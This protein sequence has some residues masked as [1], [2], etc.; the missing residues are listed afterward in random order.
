MATPK[1]VGL[2]LEFDPKIHDWTVHINRLEQFFVANTITDSDIK[3]AI[4]LNGLSQEAYILLQNLCV[5]RKP[6]ENVYEEVV[7]L[8]NEYYCRKTNVFAERC[9]FYAARKSP[10]ENIQD[11]AVKLRS[12]C[13]KCEFGDQL[14]HILR[15]K[16]ICGLNPGKIMDKMLSECRATTTFE[17]AVSLATA[18]EI[19]WRNQDENADP[20]FIKEEPREIYRV[21]GTPPRREVQRSAA[22]ARSSAVVPARNREV[23]WCSICGRGKHPGSKCFFKNKEQQPRYC[24]H[25]ST[26][27]HNTSNCRN[28][29]EKV[30]NVQLDH[31]NE[32]CDIEEFPIFTVESNVSN[33]MT[34]EVLLNNKLFILELD[35]GAAVSCLPYSVY[36]KYFENYTLNPTSITLINFTGGRISPLGKINIEVKYNNEIKFIE[37]CVIKESTVAIL[38]RDFISAFN[39][40]FQAVNHIANN[41]TWIE[42]LKLKFPDVFTDKIG[43]FNKFKLKLFLEENS[44]PKVFK[45]RPLPYALK[46][47]VERELN[48]L[49]DINILTPIEHSDW[50]T[51][52]VPVLKEDGSVRICGD[53]KLTLNP[54]L[55]DD[56]Y[57]IPRIDDL[58]A[59]LNG[60]QQFS[61]IDLS[62]AYQQIELENESAELTAI[63]TH[64]GLFFYNRLPYGIKCAPGKFQRIR[65]QLFGDMEDVCVFLDDILITGKNVYL[66]KVYNT[67]LVW[68]RHQNQLVSFDIS[69]VG[70]IDSSFDDNDEVA[71]DSYDHCNNDVSNEH[72][73]EN[74]ISDELPSDVD[75]RMIEEGNRAQKV[76]PQRTSLLVQNRPKRLRK[77]PDRWRY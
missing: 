35:S 20:S 50:G 77:S 28:K 41:N 16:F 1:T 36:Q 14:K 8:L 57:P 18:A 9:Q 4:L 37:F 53:Y 61:K 23:D 74:G 11:W 51:P 40:K 32:N 71:N 10:N 17:E 27:T 38:G 62:T 69:N 12:L 54:V 25:C 46:E 55:N 49:V 70:D 72:C 67:D 2:Q 68:K 42:K 59:K 19:T 48:R 65:D 73:L 76:T 44:V 21:Q 33:P 31:S 45:A 60:G 29:K 56:K 5:P 6:Q 75:G 64:K 22:R 34:I 43:C 24:A 15:D 13:V 66:V 30:Y 52:I 39:I 47:K 63:S 58:Y 26:K 3:R 7:K